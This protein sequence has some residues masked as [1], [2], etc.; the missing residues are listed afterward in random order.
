MRAARSGLDEVASLQGLVTAWLS[1]ICCHI[2][3]SEH[4]LSRAGIREQEQAV[5]AWPG[6]GRGQDLVAGLRV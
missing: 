6:L 2:C 4:I 5:V 1:S 3:L